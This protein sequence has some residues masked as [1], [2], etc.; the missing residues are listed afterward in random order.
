MRGSS[1]QGPGTRAYEWRQ[2]PRPGHTSLGGRGALPRWL[3]VLNE[4][5]RGA[6]V[7]KG[8]SH[9]PPC[10]STDHRL[11]RT[12]RP[13]RV[14]CPC[15]GNWCPPPQGLLEHRSPPPKQETPSP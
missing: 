1:P 14:V 7:P 3:P 5:L 12:P 9:Q 8:H 11:S 10:M 6:A 15:P 13:P 4:G 2:S